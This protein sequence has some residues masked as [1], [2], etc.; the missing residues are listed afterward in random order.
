MRSGPPPPHDRRRL[1]EPHSGFLQGCGDGRD[2]VRQLRPVPSPAIAEHRLGT[3]LAGV[4]TEQKRIRASVVR[5]HRRDE[6]ERALSARDLGRRHRHGDRRSGQRGSGHQ[7][8]VRST[9]IARVRLLRHSARPSH[10]S[11][12][13]CVRRCGRRSAHMGA[14]RRSSATAPMT[15]KRDETAPKQATAPRRRKST[16]INRGVTNVPQAARPDS[17]G[18]VGGVGVGCWE[19]ELW[20][21]PALGRLP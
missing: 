17:S 5:G 6:H 10:L 2:Y 7:R 3:N 20:P 9:P 19:Q 21:P 1:G 13:C 8:G 15:R 18:S 14:R 4:Q 11:H 12:V 16:F